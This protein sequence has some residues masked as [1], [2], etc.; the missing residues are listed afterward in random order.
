MSIRCVKC[1]TADLAEDRTIE[2]TGS[3]R[4]EE[5]TIS[6]RGMVCPNCHFQTIDGRQM[7]EY[8]R[9]LA[10]KYRAAHGLLS[11]DEIRTRRERLQMSQAKFAEY[12][13]VGIASVKRWEMGKI[14]E[15]AMDQLIRLKTEPETARQN[16]RAVESQVPEHV[17]VSTVSLGQSDID[18]EFVWN[19]SYFR[20][21]PMNIDRSLLEAIHVEDLRAA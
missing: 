1:G 8:S 6:M 11:S 20:P 16:L 4:D 15:S 12:L 19:P 9:L 7:P 13:D 2:L 21:R 5:Y 17:I 10:D 18:L 3:V 14:Q